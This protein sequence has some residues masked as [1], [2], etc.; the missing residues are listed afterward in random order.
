MNVK[1]WMVVMVMG[2]LLGGAAMAKTTNPNAN[3]NASGTSN[4]GTNNGGGNGGGNPN[5]GGGPGGGNSGDVLPSTPAPW[6]ANS[7]SPVSMV[8]EADTWAMAGAGLVVVGLVAA[9]RR[10]SA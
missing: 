10:K 2:A 6:M 1:R 7:N 4:G 3:P 8:P 9:R 5:P